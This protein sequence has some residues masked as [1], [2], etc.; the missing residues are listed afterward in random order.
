MDF[1]DPH[2]PQVEDLT[3][4]TRSGYAVADAVRSFRVSL[5]QSGSV[6]TG[7]SI[8]HTADLICSGCFELWQKI[9]WE[10]CLDHIGINS[11]RI[12][13]FLKQRFADLETAWAKLPAEQFYRTLDYQKTFVEVLLV[14]RAQPRRPALKMPR[15][16]PESHNEEW[17]RGAVQGAPSAAAVGRVFK[18]GGD[19]GILRRVGDEFARAIA[20]G[21]TEKAFWWLKWCYEEDA[22]IRRDGGG[23]L[24]TVDRGPPQ[25]SNKQRSHVSFYLANILTEIY[26]ELTAKHNLRMNEEFVAILQLFM[27][28]NKKLTLRRRTELLCLA[29]QICCEVPRWK[30]PAAPALVKDPVALERAVSHAESFFREVLAYAPPVGNVQKEAK[31]GAS[32]NIVGS[33]G[34]QL[35][36]KQLKDMN[37]QEHLNVY[38]SVI[39]NWLEGKM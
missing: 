20:E 6:A 39:N 29:I 5:E 36:A 15:V 26:K 3:L 17:V 2:E 31:R 4:R 24:S 25:W 32:K 12:F 16:P 1:L 14:V 9:L 13:W 21:A 18:G 35:T 34:R 33:S 10:Y 30:I 38:D 27:Y 28:P 8:H 7:K 19:L 23:T 11:P 22:R 37:V